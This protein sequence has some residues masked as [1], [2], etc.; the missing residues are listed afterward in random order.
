METYDT[1]SIWEELETNGVAY[2]YLYDFEWSQLLREAR[3][4]EV[5]IYRKKTSWGANRIYLRRAPQI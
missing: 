2:R 5:S 3:E 1:T 4:Y